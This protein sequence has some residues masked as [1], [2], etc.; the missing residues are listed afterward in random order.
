MK[1]SRPRVIKL[2]LIMIA[3]KKEKRMNN[4]QVT[5]KEYKKALHSARKDP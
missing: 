3:N 4:A 1:N 2:G 5:S